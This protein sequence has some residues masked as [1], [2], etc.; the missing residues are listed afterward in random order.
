MAWQ[1]L[2]VG[3]LLMNA[4]GTLTALVSGLEVSA[5]A[6]LAQLLM[7]KMSVQTKV[8]LPCSLFF[9][10]VIMFAAGMDSLLY[11]WTLHWYN[12]AWPG[13]VPAA[14]VVSVYG[15][16]IFEDK[17]TGSSLRDKLLPGIWL[18]GSLVLLGTLR[19]L[20][21]RGVWLS[22]ISL[23]LGPEWRDA[24][25]NIGHRLLLLDTPAGMLILFGLL[26]AL[27][28]YFI[29]I[30]TKAPTDSG[31]PHDDDS[32]NDDPQPPIQRPQRVRPTGHIT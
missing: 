12:P 15:Q 30:S 10:L 32:H 1:M 18:T 8:K 6:V 4:T 19:E 16:S 29:Q 3:P 14:A 25:F 13:V 26:L 20:L 7:R 11:A 31:A 9:L 24:G 21:G 23:W 22:D 28:K 17:G 27:R 5:V 2:C